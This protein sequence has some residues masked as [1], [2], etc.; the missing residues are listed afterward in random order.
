MPSRNEAMTLQ[1][2]DNK[3]FT[4][5]VRSP[6]AVHLHRVRV[7]YSKNFMLVPVSSVR[8][9]HSDFALRVTEQMLLIG[10]KELATGC[11]WPVL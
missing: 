11:D 1:M 2:D 10:L 8:S 7:S 9:V 4:P 3:K 5:S 6:D